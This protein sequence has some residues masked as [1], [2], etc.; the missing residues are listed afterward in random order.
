MQELGVIGPPLG[1]FGR[2]ELFKGPTGKHKELYEI[3]T[4]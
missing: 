2:H 4:P 3:R 1:G